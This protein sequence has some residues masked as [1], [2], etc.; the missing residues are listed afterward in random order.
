MKQY[1]INMRNGKK[2]GLSETGGKNM[3][4]R[5]SLEIS[6]WKIVEKIMH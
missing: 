1:W 5:R 4:K 3:K 6:E 2:E